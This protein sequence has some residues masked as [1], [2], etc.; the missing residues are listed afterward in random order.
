[1]LLGRGRGVTR[2]VEASMHLHGHVRGQV[3][4][5]AHHIS[6]CGPAEMSGSPL[7]SPPEKPDVGAPSR[8]LE[9]MTPRLCG[10]HSRSIQVTH[11]NPLPPCE[12]RA[13]TPA[14]GPTQKKINSKL[15]REGLLMECRVLPGRGSVH[16]LTLLRKLTFYRVSQTLANSRLTSV[17][18]PGKGD[19]P[20]FRVFHSVS[21]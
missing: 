16:V 20:F 8:G 11:S 3:T 2:G 9:K 17:N 14:Q 19:P 13:T 21:L 18:E 10:I 15:V 4:K 1:M 7:F 6:V 12:N 5:Q